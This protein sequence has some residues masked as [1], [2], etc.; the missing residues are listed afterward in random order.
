MNHSSLGR[1]LAASPLVLALAA[2]G[3]GA[4]PARGNAGISGSELYGACAS[5]HGPDG[6]GNV[7]FRAPRIAG[8]PVWYVGAQLR[9]F[10]G[11]LR[12]K[13]PD[14]VDGLRMRAMSRQ[15]LSD[16]EIDAVSQHVAQLTPPKNPAAQPAPAAQASGTPAGEEIYSRCAGCHGEKGEGNEDMKAPPL[17]RLESWYVEAQLQKFQAGVR[18][19]APNDDVG[20]MMQAVAAGVEPGEMRSVAAYILTLA[21]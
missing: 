7:A 18:G 4:A 19:T 2:A 10:K 8:L 5:C 3:C 9:R 13:H 6:S 16:A 21:K 20:S 14:D 1:L 11:D 15:M 17:A 12:G